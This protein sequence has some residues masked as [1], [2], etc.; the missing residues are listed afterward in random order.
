MAMD[1][2]HAQWCVGDRTSINGQYCTVRFKGVVPPTTG[3]WLGVEWDDPTRGKHDGQHEGVRYFHVRNGAE[4]GGSFVRL[5]KV[6]KCMSLEDAVRDRYSTQLQ[7]GDEKTTFVDSKAQSI[8]VVLVGADKA[9]G[10]QSQISQLRDVC[11]QSMPIFGA[12]NAD[13]LDT[14]LPNVVHLDI[15]KTLVSSWAVVVSIVRKLHRLREL[16]VCSNHFSDSTTYLPSVEGRIHSVEELFLN[17][18]QGDIYASTDY[19]EALSVVS[20]LFPKLHALHVAGNKTTTLTRDDGT[21]GFPPCLKLLNL[22]DNLLRS[23]NDVRALGDLETLENLNI[24]KNGISSITMQGGDAVFTRLRVLN[25]SRNNLT[26]WTSVSELSRLPAL[27]ELIIAHNPLF[28]GEKGLHVRQSIIAR[29]PKLRRLNK[30]DVTEQ[31]RIIA[32]RF[33]LATYAKEFWAVKGAPEDPTA[34]ISFQTE[35]PTYG[36]LVSKHGEPE[37]PKAVTVALKDGFVRIHATKVSGGDVQIQLPKTTT[38]ARLR[39]V[40]KA[41]KVLPPKGD[42]SVL[43]YHGDEDGSFDVEL[44]DD[45]RDLGFFDV[46]SGRVAVKQDPFA[47]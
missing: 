33:Y 40:L 45:M 47:P 34:A 38:V 20:R 27:E 25:I 16:R 22:E 28:D 41:K 6:D 10:E 37:Q 29:L 19:A 15:S 17:T 4:K 14:F 12:K 31:E 43:I 32:E 36:L 39:Q 1:P 2:E 21:H 5:K 9:F 18:M 24:A 44:D 30:S 35:H 23:W 13:L 3:E 42:F 7:E 11:I 26:S 8:D 46:T